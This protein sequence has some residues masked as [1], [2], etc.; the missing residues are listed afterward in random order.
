MK[1]KYLLSSSFLASV[2]VMA[3]M[4]SG[5]DV[6]RR[7]EP[8]GKVSSNSNPEEMEHSHK[9]NGGQE[10]FDRVRAN[11]LTGKVE[12]QDAIDAWHEVVEINKRSSRSLGLTF[13]EMGPDNIGGRV[14]SILIDKDDSDK[15]FAGGVSGGLFVSENGGATWQPHPDFWST[16]TTLEELSLHI[17]T[18]AQAPNGDIYVGTGNTH[19][20]SASGPGKGIYKSTDGGNSFSQLPATV[21]T[22]YTTTGDWVYV[23]KI[24]VDNQGNVYAGTNSGL[25]VSTDGGGTWTQ[26]LY[27]QTCFTVLTQEIDDIEVTDDGRLIVVVDGPDQFY[28][29]DQPTVACSYSVATGVPSF[30]RADVAIAPSDNSMMYAVIGGDDVIPQ[31][32]SAGGTY[33]QDVLVSTDKGATWSSYSPSAPTYAVDTTFALYGDNGQGYYDM[34]IA[35]QP[36]DKYRFYLGGV[37]LY[38]VKDS[39]TRPAEWYYSPTSEY[40]VHADMHD[41]QFDPKDPSKMYIASDGGIGVSNNAGSGD[42]T[43]TT[44][45]RGFNITQFYAIAMSHDG[46]IVGGT[47]DNGTLFI[48]PR[49]AA[50]SMSASEIIGGDGFGCAYSSIDEILFGSLY[51]GVV[52]RFSGSNFAADVI[53]GSGGGPFNTIVGLWENINDLTSKDSVTFR[54]DTTEIGI[55]TGDETKR[56]F[57]GTLD[58]LQSTGEIILGSIKFAEDKA[59]NPQ[60]AVDD[61]GD[62]VIRMVGT[63]DSIGTFD[64]LTNEYALR[65]PVAPNQGIAVYGYLVARYDAGDTLNLLSNTA[66]FPF[67]YV[68]PFNLEANDSVVVQ[69]PVQSMFVQSQGSGLGFTRQ[70]LNL[71]SLPSFITI[72]ESSDNGIPTCVE[73]SKDGNS[74]YVGTSSGNVVRFDGLNDLYHNVTYPDSVVSSSIIFN[75]STV[76]GISLSPNDQDRLVIT[77]GGF[78]NTSGNVFEITNASTATSTS[79]AVRRN[80]QGNLPQMPVYDAEYSNAGDTVLIGTEY[81]LWATSDVTAN[82]VVWEDE[83]GNMGNTMVLDVKQQRLPS[84]RAENY[85]EFYI[86]THGRGI[87]TTSDLV[88]EPSGFYEGTPLSKNFESNMTVYPNPMSANGAIEFE[89]PQTSKATVS[90]INIEGQVVRTYRNKQFQKGTNTMKLNVSDIPAGTYF[91][92]VTSGEYYSVAKFVVV[93]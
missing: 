18:I 10:F 80:I 72:P 19:E 5:G 59:T 79:S 77:V 28:Y 82:P 22:A 87:W 66:D 9:G 86:G 30:I 3:I 88:G 25:Q 41:I 43:F 26:P 74:L 85:D 17:S 11:A 46:R 56:N 40:Y 31:N 84:W 52:T 71:A 14:R 92:T 47:Q 27:D 60:V 57:T 21:P 63:N 2:V 70:A 69:D 4:T 16:T 42:M 44:A 78:G 65:W 64:Y 81:G 24:V 76:T 39:W 33:L 15:L 62:G 35:V 29:S 55:G 48:D 54:A 50:N 12:P 49:T 23:N 61:N 93:R 45:L 32:G 73:F 38:S 51:Y 58:P 91:I 8:R 67:N 13:N 1:I 37:Q 20:G 89:M 34:C 83:S 75:G 7:Y 90:V 6:V 53:S 68:L 36:D